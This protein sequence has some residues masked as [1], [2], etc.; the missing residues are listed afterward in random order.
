MSSLFGATASA[1]AN[2]MEGAA[3]GRA[4]GDAR[5]AADEAQFEA[6]QLKNYAKQLELELAKNGIKQLQRPN[7]QRP[8]NKI[9]FTLQEFKYLL[10]FGLAVVILLACVLSYFVIQDYVRAARRENISAEMS[11][12][13]LGNVDCK[14]TGSR[15]L[16]INFK[17]WPTVD[18]WGNFSQFQSPN[19]QGYFEFIPA[20][21]K[22][23]GRMGLDNYFNIGLSQNGEFNF[24][25][26]YRSDKYAMSGKYDMKT[27]TLYAVVEGCTALK[28]KKQPLQK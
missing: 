2:A 20:L 10:K 17:V 22:D 11:G 9:A 23:K 3:I 26:G 4:I 6:E 5:D 15:Q 8:S 7:L 14:G 27:G 18:E 16:R 21:S 13:W 24:P 25:R 19:A 1:A 28:G 12:V